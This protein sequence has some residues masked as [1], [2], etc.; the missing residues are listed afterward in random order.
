MMFYKGKCRV[1]HL[2]RNNPKYQDRLRAELAERCSA[3]L[4][5]LVDEVENELAGEGD[6]IS[7]KL[8][9]CTP[10]QHL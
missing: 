5:V 10:Q 8:L 7:V 2:G 3:D 4:G 9:G 1:M 6:M